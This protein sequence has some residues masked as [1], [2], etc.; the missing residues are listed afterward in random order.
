MAVVAA[1]LYRHGERVRS[2]AI[3]EKCDCADDKSSFVWIG[4]V[5]PT[6]EEMAAL[7]HTYDL[8]PLAIEDALN[9]NQ[10]PK[11]DVYGDQLFIIA[12][13]A[14]LHGESIEY[15][16]TALFVGH[17]HIITVRHG[18]ERAHTALREQLEKAPK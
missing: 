8:H 1:Y 15:G 18:S 9:T 6:V 3:D 14:R 17:S 5:D 16:E 4:I 13:T 2:I 11:I 12:R 7:Q 10:L